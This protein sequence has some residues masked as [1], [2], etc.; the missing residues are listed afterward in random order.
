M[1]EPGPGLGVPVMSPVHGGQATVH[2]SVAVQCTGLAVYKNMLSTRDGHSP[3]NWHSR[4]TMGPGGEL[5]G[6]IGVIA[7]VQYA[8]VE[9]AVVHGS[10]PGGR[11]ARR[12]SNSLQ[13]LLHKLGCIWESVRGALARLGPSVSLNRGI[14]RSFFFIIFSLSFFFCLQSSQFE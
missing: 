12:Y 2:W 3:E 13:V 9:D 1:L 8:E 14:G 4:A 11:Q 10:F 5:L 7:D 6:R